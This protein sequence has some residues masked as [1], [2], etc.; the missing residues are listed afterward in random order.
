MTVVETEI[1]A[2]PDQVFSVLADAKQ[3]G[4]WVVGS[5][6]VLSADATFPAQG[7]RFRHVQGAFGVGIKDDTVVLAAERPYH[8]RLHVMARPLVRAEVDI[9]LSATP[10]GTHLRME[11]TIVGGVQRRAPAAVND[12]L[13]RLRNKESLRRLRRIAERRG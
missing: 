2:T 8:L 7:T 13:L 3:Y 5:S 1:A 4:S 11:E 6:K 12:A 10:D 9:Q